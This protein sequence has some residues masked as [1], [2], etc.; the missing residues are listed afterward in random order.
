MHRSTAD[1]GEQGRLASVGF[2]CTKAE[3]ARESDCH[4]DFGAYADLVSFVRG[5]AAPTEPSDL[6]STIRGL[7]QRALSFAVAVNTK[8]VIDWN[9]H[10]IEDA[11]DQQFVELLSDLMDRQDELRAKVRRRVERAVFEQ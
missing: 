7:F 10:S 11:I 5:E 4:Q 6:G 2:V 9:M 3:G 8:A 1:A